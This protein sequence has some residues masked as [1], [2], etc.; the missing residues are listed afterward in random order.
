MQVFFRIVALVIVLP[1]RCTSC[2]VDASVRC[3]PRGSTTLSDSP[4]PE[5]V[6]VVTRLF[7][8]RLRWRRHMRFRFG[9]LIK[10]VMHSL[11]RRSN[12]GLTYS[13]YRCRSGFSDTPSSRLSRQ[14]RPLI[15]LRAQIDNNPAFH[16]NTSETSTHESSRY[17]YIFDVIGPFFSQPR[18]DKYRRTVTRSGEHFL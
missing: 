11:V 6:Q 14:R 3:F 2:L 7:V 15:H 16:K 17:F 12:K 1:H 5:F 18:A 13:K 10:E 8:R 4:L 9:R